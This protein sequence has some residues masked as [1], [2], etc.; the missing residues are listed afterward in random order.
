MYLKIQGDL[1]VQFPSGIHYVI[2]YG[3][4]YTTTT[5]VYHWEIERQRDLVQF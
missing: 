4:H 3:I 5:N 2:H 1:V